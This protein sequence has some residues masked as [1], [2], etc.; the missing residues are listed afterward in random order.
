MSTSYLHVCVRD[1]I[2]PFNS[3]D[4]VIELI[5]VNTMHGKLRSTSMKPHVLLQKP[6]NN[7]HELLIVFGLTYEK[8]VYMGNKCDF[9][10]GDVKRALTASMQY[11]NA[12][13]NLN[14]TR[15]LKSQFV[16]RSKHTP[17]RL[18]K[19]LTYYLYGNSRFV[20]R[21]ITMVTETLCGQ[22]CRIY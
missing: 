4:L 16:P 20:L 7:S 6:Q 12:N 3:Y 1:N 8:Y 21:S 5:W 15:H 19:S 14:H 18:S 13:I 10:N 9:E 22:K 11:I 2:S 17:S